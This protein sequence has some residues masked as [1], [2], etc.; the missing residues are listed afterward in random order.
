MGQSHYIFA[1]GGG[2]RRG[3]GGFKRGRRRLKILD[4]KNRLGNSEKTL[5]VKKKFNEKRVDLVT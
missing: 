2:R 4:P 1:K 3:C 5:R